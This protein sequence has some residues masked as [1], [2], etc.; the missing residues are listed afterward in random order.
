MCAINIC[1]MAQWDA[2]GMGHGGR[3]QMNTV[4]EVL[5]FPFSHAPTIP[6]ARVF[7]N[8]GR[9]MYIV[10]WRMMCVYCICMYITYIIHR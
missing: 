6:H 1:E 8:A 3:K 9:C 5:D 7:V 2:M 10:T 4:T